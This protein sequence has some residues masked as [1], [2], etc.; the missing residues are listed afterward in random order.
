MTRYLTLALFLALVVGGGS[1]VGA[2]N[3]PGEWYQALNKPSFNPPNWLFGPVWTLLYVM[4][5]IAGWR[6][7]SETRTGGAMTAWWVQL[8]L[9]FLWSPVFFTL[10]SVG[11][12]LAII[13]A[14]LVA[15][16]TFVVLAWDRDRVA[17][18]LFVP[19][20]LWVGFATVLNASIWF[21]N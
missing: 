9:N 8:G 2:N 7:W 19:Y 5:A 17:A 14:M 20:A 4:I 16:V 15:I 1:L 13:I 11:G 21:L 3:I 12:A 10:Q 18:S 6:I